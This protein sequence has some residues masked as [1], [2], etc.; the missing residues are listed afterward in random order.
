MRVVQKGI[1]DELPRP[2]EDVALERLQ[3]PQRQQSLELLG[4]RKLQQINQGVDAD[5]NNDCGNFH[6]GR[7][8]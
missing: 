6:M 1:G 8:F 4:A 5:Q 3:R 7:I 2:E